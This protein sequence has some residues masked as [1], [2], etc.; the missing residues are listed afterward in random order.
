MH[1]TLILYMIS[2]IVL[3]GKFYVKAYIQKYKDYREMRHQRAAN[4]K[5]D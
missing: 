2:F 4:V 5:L 1:Y 3:F